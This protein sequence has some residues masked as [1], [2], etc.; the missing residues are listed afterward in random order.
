G[1]I[2]SGPIAAAAY[3]LL[4]AC[5]GVV[6]RVVLAGPAHRVYVKGA[7]ASTAKGF[8]TPFGTVPV[9]RGTVD[10]LLELPFVEASD[11]AHA[12]EHSLEV[13]VP[14]LQS[15]LVD[16]SLVPIVVGHAA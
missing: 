12:F 6:K 2:Y 10:R 4:G 7:A 3:A 5:R 13:H 1:Y 11:A 9:D 8:D 14:F 15:A 16:F